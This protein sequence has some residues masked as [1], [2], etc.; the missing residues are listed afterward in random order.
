[1]SYVDDYLGGADSQQEAM[2]LQGDMHSLFLKGGFL[3][4]KWSCSDPTVLESISPDL[5]ESQAAVVLS[6]SDRYSKTLGIEWNASSDHF[7]VSVTELPHIECMTKRSLVSGVAKTFDALGW[8]SPAIVKAKVLLQPFGLKGLVGMIVFLM[9]SS[10]N[11]RSGDEN[12]HYSPPIASHDVI[13]PRKLPLFPPSYTGF[14]MPQRRHVLP[15]FT[16]EW[17]TLMG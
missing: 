10:K 5:R 12:C 13:T 6:D 3:L 9:L 7:R 4:R 2:K 17:R 8:Y 1:M 15:L 14:Q 11:G 16:S